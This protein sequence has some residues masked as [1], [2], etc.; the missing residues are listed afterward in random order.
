MARAVDATLGGRD[1]AVA[2]ALC[3]RAA[4]PWHP[5]HDIARWLQRRYFLGVSSTLCPPRPEGR[6]APETGGLR[7]GPGQKAGISRSTTPAFREICWTGI[8][9]AFAPRLSRWS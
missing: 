4:N 7:R 5:R 9:L 1:R 6:P 3:R 8:I 2:T